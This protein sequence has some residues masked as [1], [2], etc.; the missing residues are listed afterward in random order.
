MI[1]WFV[2]ELLGQNMPTL[3]LA[4]IMNGSPI[5]HPWLFWNGMTIYGHLQVLS[6]DW[7]DD[8]IKLGYVTKTVVSL[9]VSQTGWCRCVGSIRAAIS[10]IKCIE[11]L[12]TNEYRVNSLVLAAA[13][14]VCTDAGHKTITTK[15][16]ASIYFLQI[17]VRHTDLQLW[18]TTFRF[19][20]YWFV[21][22]SG[23][24]WKRDDGIYAPRFSFST[25]RCSYQIPSICLYL[26]VSW[27]SI[28]FFWCGL[29]GFASLGVPVLCILT[30]WP[31][32]F[33]LLRTG[34]KDTTE[35][36]FGWKG[37]HLWFLMG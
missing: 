4:T 8:L 28:Q 12:V 26:C 13:V 15:L 22:S 16:K 7:T 35:R 1:S 36:D 21:L 18:T 9:G 19:G 34:C 29:C 20:L 3:S 6:V 14:H 5:Q 24:G 10:F 2:V 31:Q 27:D 17:T 23:K 33:E 25:S 11:G 30:V 32:D 37:N